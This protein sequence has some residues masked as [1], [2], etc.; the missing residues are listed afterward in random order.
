MR[1]VSKIG[2]AA[3]AVLLGAIAGAQAAETTTAK[4]TEVASLEPAKSAVQ[5]STPAEASKPAKAVKRKVAPRST[6][7][8]RINLSTQQMAVREHGKTLYTWKISSGRAGYITPR[9]RFR[10]KWA[11]KMWYSRKYDGAPMPYAVFFNGG[12]ATH[13]TAAVSRL[14]RPASHGCIRLRTPNARRLYQL[15]HRHGYARTRFVVVGTTPLQKARKRYVKRTT[16]RRNTRRFRTV[17]RVS[18]VP[19]RSNRRVRVRRTV[20][21]TPRLLY[22]GDAY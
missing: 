20:S 4:P 11:S 13:G 6:L 2:F 9:G 14:G 16:L 19:R 3:F 22:P 12:I 17:R 18:S 21:R 8:V 5:S 1:G 7:E 10:P 15:V